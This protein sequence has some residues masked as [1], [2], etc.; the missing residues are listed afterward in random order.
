MILLRYL[1]ARCQFPFAVPS[2]EQT[3]GIVANL[4]ANVVHENV[5]TVD[6]SSAIT[7]RIN[8]QGTVISVEVASVSVTFLVTMVVTRLL[9]A[10]VLNAFFSLQFQIKI[11]RVHGFRDVRARTA[12]DTSSVVRIVN[13]AVL[14]GPLGW[15]IASV[16]AKK[17][18]ANGIGLLAR[19]TGAFVSGV[20]LAVCSGRSR[21]TITSVSNVS[22]G[23]SAST[24]IQARLSV[25]IG[26]G[27]FAIVSVIVTRAETS[28]SSL[29]R[30]ANPSILTR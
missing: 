15:A 19:I 10:S 20:Y 13:F 9:F 27:E 28:V 14:T 11:V 12:K 2:I 24:A 8:T 4:V 21:G 26:A 22:F 3:L 17:V 30:G 25:A 7:P 23:H 6:R 18:F 1:L 29:L 5:P 16:I